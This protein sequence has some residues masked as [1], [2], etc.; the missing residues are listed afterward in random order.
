MIRTLKVCIYRAILAVFLE[1]EETA[2]IKRTWARVFTRLK[3]V[4]LVFKKV[5]YFMYPL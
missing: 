2:Q 5:N 3:H 4:E 1:P